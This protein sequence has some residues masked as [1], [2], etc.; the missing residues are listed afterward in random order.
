MLK[1]IE[2]IKLLSLSKKELP[3]QILD[4]NEIMEE[5]SLKSGPE[6]GELLKLLREEQLSGRVK[7]KKQA[8][9]FLK[10]IYKK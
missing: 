9:K 8:L 2:E 6:V 4:G 5:F 3:K 10:I 7:T 1:R